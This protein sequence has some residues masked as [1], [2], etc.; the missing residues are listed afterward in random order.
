MSCPVCGSHGVTTTQYATKCNNCLF[1]F[2]QDDPS[3]FGANRQRNNFC[4]DGSSHRWVSNQW[5]TKCDK[6]LFRMGS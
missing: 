4:K 1:R 3:T 6:C 5:G 2:G